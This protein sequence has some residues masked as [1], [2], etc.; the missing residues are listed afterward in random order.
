MPHQSVNLCTNQQKHRY[1]NE[2]IT[3][4]NL[5]H[6][7]YLLVSLSKDGKRKQFGVHRLVAT[8]FLDNP[9]NY[10]CVNHKDENKQNNNLQNLEWCSY[11]Y[12]NNYGTKNERASKAMTNHPRLSYKIKCLDLETK[13][14]IIFPS[15]HE[16]SR[17]FN[18]NDHGSSIRYHIKR[19]SVFQNRYIFSIIENK[20]KN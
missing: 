14:E 6:S 1:N 7:G 15:M 4:G 16:A 19:N 8:A 17:F 11:S 5:H 12:N 9:N 13:E 3:K 10:P 18:K 2:K 20:Y